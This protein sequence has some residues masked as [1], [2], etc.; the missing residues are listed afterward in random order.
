MVV[1]VHPFPTQIRVELGDI[2]DHV[3]DD[4]PMHQVAGMV[5]H[6]PG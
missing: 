1:A 6:R 2:I 3:S 4:L 5:E